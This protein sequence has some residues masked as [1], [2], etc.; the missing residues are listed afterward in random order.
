MLRIYCTKK[1]EKFI[2][3]VD[4]E[5]P[6]D[7]IHRSI[8]DW[9]A[10]LFF[11]ERKKCIAF[12][13]NR[14]AYSVFLTDIKKKDLEVIDLYFYRRLINQFRH[15]KVINENESFEK[16]FP[17]GNLKFYKTNNDRKTIGRINDFVDMFKT[18]LDYKYGELKYMDIT[19]ENGLF[20][21]TLTGIPG[22]TKKT[23]SNPVENMINEIKTSAQH[24][25]RCTSP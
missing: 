14:T 4:Q 6:S 24:G 5:L 17:S 16:L 20:N 23:W 21:R 7:I 11:V 12:I 8:F 2:G 25:N 13:N 3:N 9:N 15:D 1:L 22:E 19:Y 10:H 18:H